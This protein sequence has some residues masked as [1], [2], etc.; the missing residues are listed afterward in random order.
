MIK[1]RLA[2]GLALACVAAALAACQGARGANGGVKAADSALP[3]ATKLEGSPTNARKAGDVSSPEATTEETTAPAQ[4]L[5]QSE[6]WTLPKN[7]DKFPQTI[8]DDTVPVQDDG[9]TRIVGRSRYGTLSLRSLDNERKTKYDFIFHGD[10][11]VVWKKADDSKETRISLLYDLYL[12]SDAGTAEMQVYTF[13]DYDV[14]LMQPVYAWYQ[15]IG[16]PQTENVYAFAVGADGVAFPL[17]F[18]SEKAGEKTDSAIIP[19]EINNRITQENDRLLMDT[20]LP[21]LTKV[22]FTPD[23]PQKRLMLISREDVS[24]EHKKAFDLAVRYADVLEAAITLEWQEARLYMRGEV[25]T[26]ADVQPYFTDAGWNSPVLQEAIRQGR[27]PDNGGTFSR[28]FRWDPIYCEFAGENELHFTYTMNTVNAIG[29][30]YYMDVVVKK[31]AA[32]WKIAQVDNMRRQPPYDFQK[33]NG[34]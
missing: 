2:I 20:L 17:R 34:S 22:E 7:G 26:M 8:L 28:P 6:V 9:Q 11:E 25:K 31:D 32:G 30:A 18:F 13:G 1:R 27:L 21:D 16:V 3:T 19:V 33:T 23:F 29:V 15:S 12:P 10:Y 24:V 4:L 14:L 5:D